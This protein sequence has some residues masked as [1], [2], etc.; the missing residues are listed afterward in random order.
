[1]QP[2]EFVQFLNRTLVI[3]AINSLK[4]Y[5]LIGRPSEDMDYQ[6]FREL[7]IEF[8]DSG[9]VALYQYSPDTVVVTAIKHQKEMGY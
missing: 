4:Q 1:M 5:P 6:G 9:Y 7:L 8:G 3:N 2:I